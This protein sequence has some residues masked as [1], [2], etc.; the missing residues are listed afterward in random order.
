MAKGLQEV[1]LRPYPGR[2][3]VARTQED[4]LK[5][6]KRLYGAGDTLGPTVRGRCTGGRI[7]PGEPMTYLIW[8]GPDSALPH[9]VAHVVLDVF[10]VC[11]IDPR[12]ANGEPFCYMLDHLLDQL[13]PGR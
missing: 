3:Y 13:L 8:A 9:E 12:E 2:L 7:A 6:H 1:S 10:S 5:A 11:G 4:Y